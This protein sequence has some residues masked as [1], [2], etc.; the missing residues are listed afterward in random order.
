MSVSF[1]WTDD[2]S[3]ILRSDSGTVI[4]EV[5]G[6][7]TRWSLKP[8]TIVLKRDYDFRRRPRQQRWSASDLIDYQF[9]VE[10]PS[11]Y[12]S[13]WTAIRPMPKIQ[14]Y[15]IYEYSCHE[16]NYAMSNILSGERQ[17]EKTAARD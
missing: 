11:V 15:R 17:R 16:G 9:M 1:R 10:D 5:I 14:D 3:W 4:P 2:H 7:V 6:K 13:A 8:R 12:T